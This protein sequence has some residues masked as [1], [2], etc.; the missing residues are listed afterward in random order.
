MD[1]TIH[2][3]EGVASVNGCFTFLYT[4]AAFL[5]ACSLIPLLFNSDMSDYTVLALHNAAKI[6]QNL[7]K[8]KGLSFETTI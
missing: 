3:D 6:R 8:I 4:A 5:D 1:S 2:G 7:E